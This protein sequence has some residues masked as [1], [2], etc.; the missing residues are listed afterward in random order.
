V[1]NGAWLWLLWPGCALAAVACI[2]WQGNASLFRNIGGRMEDAVA[3]LLAPYLIGAWLNSRLWTYRNPEPSKIAP[4]LYLSRC[5]T[6][7]DVRRFEFQSL[8]SCCPEI[9]VD[10]GKTPIYSVAVL[11]LLAPEIQQIE[12]GVAAIDAASQHGKTL[13]FCALGYS[14]SAT[15]AAA[16]LLANGLAD[17][18]DAAAAQLRSVRPG[19]VMSAKH[20]RQLKA[21]Q[22]WRESTS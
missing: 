20:I 19:L 7:K 11:D 4:N 3:V 12:Q 18:I 10:A 6:A 14:R 2:Y 1:L 21:W 22:A 8:V 9:M 16:W 17:S 15:I 13:L 5:P